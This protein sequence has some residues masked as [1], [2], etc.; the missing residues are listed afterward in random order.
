M[1]H[2]P[3]PRNLPPMSGLSLVSPQNR[4]HSTRP[5]PSAIQIPNNQPTHSHDEDIRSP[6]AKRRRTVYGPITSTTAAAPMPPTFPTAS[7][8]RQSF[9]H[10]DPRQYTPPGTA[11]PHQYPTSHAPPPPPSASAV[12]L[13]PLANANPPT[14]QSHTDTLLKSHPY[15]HPLRSLSRIAP[16]LPPATP[17]HRTRGALIALEGD[18]P[19]ALATLSAHLATFLRTSHDAHVRLADGPAVPPA[20]RPATTDDYWALVSE[21]RAH[22]RDIAAFLTTPLFKAHGVADEDVAPDETP[23]MLVPV[24]LVAGYMLHAADR[25]AAAVPREDGGCYSRGEHWSW[26]ATLWRGVVGADVTVVVRDVDAAPGF[27]GGGRGVEVLE[28]LRVVLVK[29]GRGEAIGEKR[30]RRVGFEIGEILRGVQAQGG[31]VAE[32]ER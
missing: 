28:E 12:R 30:L 13:P 26:M 15:L 9:S 31:A 8:Y 27:A 22:S 18:D 3:N 6:D 10:P 4:R 5:H 7:P 14:P 32:G 24:V 21:W 25:W 17:P 20:T 16:P 23:A 2:M 19:A 11:Q 1:G 29:K